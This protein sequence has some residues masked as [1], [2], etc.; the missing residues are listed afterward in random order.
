MPNPIIGETKID[1]E[2]LLKV[3]ES[4]ECRAFRDWLASTDSLSDKELK[5]RISGVTSKIRQALNSKW[6]KSVRFLVSNGLSYAGPLGIVAGPVA[7]VIDGFILERLAPKDAIL[8]FL[9]E[10][11]PA[12]LKRE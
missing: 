12:L 1:A 2:K 6:G 10:G 9:I 3:R 4:D 8:S 5:D 11:Y 7:T